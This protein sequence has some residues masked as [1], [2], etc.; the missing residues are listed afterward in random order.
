V[1]ALVPSSPDSLVTVTS[2]SRLSG[3]EADLW[4]ELGDLSERAAVKLLG[5]LIGA[6]R[7]ENEHAAVAKIIKSCGS[8]PLAIRVI[9]GKLAPL[10]HLSLTEFADRLSSADPFA[11]L[12]SGQ[13]SV[14]DRYARWYQELPEESKAAARCLAELSSAPFTHIE[15]CQ[16]LAFAGFAPDRTFEL[17]FELSMLST[18]EQFDEVTAHAVADV[19]LHA[20]MYEMP[21]LMRQ[22]L[23]R[24]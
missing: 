5:R 23:L 21:P 22:F 9:G 18:S 1:D 12:V 20:E 6:A 14:Q 2:R 8:S 15:A 24:G 17:L 10:A 11:E 4:I 3:L 7:V 16:A 19:T 13:A